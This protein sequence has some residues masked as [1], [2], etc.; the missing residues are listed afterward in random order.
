VV[1]ASTSAWLVSIARP[2]P[3]GPVAIVAAIALVVGHAA[4]DR[5]RTAFAAELADRLTDIAVLGALAWRA[6]GPSPRV[7]V[8]AVVLLGTSTSAAYVASRA[9]SLGYSVTD[10][11]WYRGL[12]VVLI[13]AGLAAGRPAE[14]LYAAIALAASAFAYRWTE[15]SRQGGKPLPSAVRPATEERR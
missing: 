10:P 3:A 13:G 12:R 11:P 1:L 9:R 5:P 14:G 6:F 2:R 15:V 7:A 4:R 8:A